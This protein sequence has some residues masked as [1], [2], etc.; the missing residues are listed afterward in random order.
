M[1]IDSNTEEE[2]QEAIENLLKAYYEG[3][4]D[5]NHPKYHTI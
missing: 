2:D 4:F 5:M 3:F 1:D